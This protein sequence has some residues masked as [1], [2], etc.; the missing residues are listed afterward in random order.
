M[1]CRYN[2]YW[3]PLSLCGI[4]LSFNMDK[5]F[6]LFRKLAVLFKQCLPAEI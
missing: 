1:S 3:D 2:W 6:H 4:E 5:M